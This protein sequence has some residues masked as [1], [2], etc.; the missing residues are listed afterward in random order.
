MKNFLESERYQRAIELFDA[1]NAEDT[2]KELD[3][4]GVEQPKRY[5]YGLRMSKALAEF[6][7]QASEV[8]SLAVRCQHIY[9]WKVPRDS[10]P[11][12]RAGYLKW[13]EY[14]KGY[15]GIEAGKIMQQ[16]GYSSQEIEELQFILLKKQLKSNPDTQT[17]EDIIC[18]VFLQYNFADFAAG[19]ISKD[20]EKLINIIR[21]TWNKMSEKG[22]QAALKLNYSES[23]LNLIKKALN[24]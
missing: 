7:S 17:L 8:L 23:S 2:H 13:R 6:E 22:N 3:E 15:H 5:L 11:M 1:A 10:Y 19:D 21:R 18:L 12:N 16:V 14:L 24:L 9:R 4:N 20:E